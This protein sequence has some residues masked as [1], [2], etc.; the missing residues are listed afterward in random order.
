MNS[1]K[2]KSSQVPRSEPRIAR[3][4][5]IMATSP[6]RRRFMTSPRW[7]LM[8]PELRLRSY[9][10]LVMGNRANEAIGWRFATAGIATPISL[11]R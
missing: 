9:C 3:I 8:T 2:A 6:Q 11:L 4:M 7:S 5:I 1:G 10:E